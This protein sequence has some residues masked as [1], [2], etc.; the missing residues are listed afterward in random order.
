MHMAY[1]TYLPPDSIREIRVVQSTDHVN[2]PQREIFF[3]G[4]FGFFI[5][6]VIP[7][8]RLYLGFLCL[9]FFLVNELF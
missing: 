1:D 5:V 9:S 8:V 3:H 6:V 2:S 4:H 7:G